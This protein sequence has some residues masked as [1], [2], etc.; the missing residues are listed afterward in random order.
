MRFSDGGGMMLV[1]VGG[2]V[3]GE[4]APWWFPWV[5]IGIL[6]DYTE[7]LSYNILRHYI[8]CMY[9]HTLYYGHLF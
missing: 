1:E 4:V 6:V 5:S 7:H 8:R 3:L 9:G 2:V